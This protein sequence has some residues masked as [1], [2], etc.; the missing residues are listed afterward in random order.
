MRTGTTCKVVT[1]LEF[2]SEVQYAVPGSDSFSNGTELARVYDEYAREMY[3]Y[4]EKVMMQIPCE[5]EPGARYSLV[6][7][8]DNCKQAY[9]RWL[10]TVAVPRCEDVTSGTPS[11]FI[12]NVGQPFPNG[13]MLPEEFIEEWSGKVYHNASRNRF[14]DDEIAPGPYKEILPCEDICYEVVQNCPSAIG[15]SCPR[16]K[17]TA[18][19]ASYGRRTEENEEL[20]CNYPGEFR[21][22]VS[23]ANFAGVRRLLLGVGLL[24]SFRFLLL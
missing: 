11:A 14:I 16:P 7:G 5:A 17:M 6:R 9:K 21:T 4:F 8:C 24:V 3:S 20:S 1:D 22:R 15:F 10:C 19:G 23:A 18:F 2:C 12:R 13:T